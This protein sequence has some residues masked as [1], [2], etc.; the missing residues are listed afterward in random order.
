MNNTK[1]VETIR[2]GALAA[3][4]WEREGSKG[5]YFEF[6]LSRSYQKDGKF[7]YSTTFHERDAESLRRVVE[8]A[9]ISIRRRNGAAEEQQTGTGLGSGADD[10]PA[11]PCPA[12]ACEATAGR[13]I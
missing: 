8:L 4:I 3:S 12:S 2:D 7:A 5:R 6:T 11:S 9:A 13:D 10:A 1:P